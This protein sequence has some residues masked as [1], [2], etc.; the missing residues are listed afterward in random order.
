[1][2]TSDKKSSDLGFLS[3]TSQKTGH[4]Y[5]RNLWENRY[6]SREVRNRPVSKGR[7]NAMQTFLIQ[8]KA[9]SLSGRA[10]R[11][12]FARIAVVAVATVLSVG[13][14]G[15]G[16]SASAVRPLIEPKPKSTAAAPLPSQI[17]IVMKSKARVPGT[18]FT[19]RID[20]TLSS[21]CP[22][23]VDCV[24]AGEFKLG[25]RVFGGGLPKAGKVLNLTYAPG[26][27]FGPKNRAKI[28]GWWFG[29]AASPTQDLTLRVQ[30]DAFDAKIAD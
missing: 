15:S 19:V 29:I 22:Q 14:I 10:E 18:P 23:G 25:A 6:S 28:K 7:P 17:P 16:A 9:I 12:R 4:F 11:H 24:W 13:L 8:S 20:S 3:V 26:N 27:G 2:V 21:L 1:V 30:P 5:G